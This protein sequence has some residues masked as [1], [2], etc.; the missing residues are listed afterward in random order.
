[1]CVASSC[2][3]VDDEPRPAPSPFATAVAAFDPG[4]HAGFGQSELPG[5]V[6]GP[7]RGASTAAGSTDVVS[8]GLGGVIVLELG[9]DVGDGDG[10]DFHVF[11]N[12]FLVAGGPAVNGEPGEVSVS[13]DGET[14]ATF[15]CAPD[16]E[17]PNGCAGFTP[18]IADEQG[19]VV[20]GG[21]AF[22]L[23]ELADAPATVRFVRIT[24]RSTAGGEPTA[25]F[26][27]DA[28]GAAAR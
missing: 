26:D 12:P 21:D 3:P 25:G 1:M 17:P 28:V 14:F 11:E 5:V 16:V 27:L 23:A 2:G 19:A 7:P 6:L 10:P 13:A 9:V 4:E 15:P 20:E 8:L 18:V 24:D 22:D